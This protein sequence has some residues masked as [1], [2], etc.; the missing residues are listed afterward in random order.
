LGS[1]DSHEGN[2]QDRETHRASV[3]IGDYAPKAGELPEGL[4]T[5][6]AR[7]QRFCRICAREGLDVFDGTE[8][9]KSAN[10]GAKK[11]MSYS[12]SIGT[13]DVLPSFPTA[14]D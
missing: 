4:D 10:L 2:E 6:L 14:H 1:A 8:N 11:P 13:T 9:W 5:K 7:W 12:D 3:F